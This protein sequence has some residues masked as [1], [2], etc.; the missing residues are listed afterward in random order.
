MPTWGFSDYRF[1]YSEKCKC[2]W[3]IKRNDA[4]LLET[5]RLACP[6]C[7]AEIGKW[8]EKRARETLS[9][10]KS[11]ELETKEVRG[12]TEELNQVPGYGEHEDSREVTIGN[13]VYNLDQFRIQ[14][15]QVHTLLQLTM[16]VA[17]GRGRIVG[18]SNEPI[19]DGHRRVI[20]IEIDK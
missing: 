7:K 2:G 20:S 1:F 4:V 3:V 6:L 14:S 18:E 13:Y 12:V 9:F 5:Y 10:L 15:E 11:L 17:S 8:D 16:H 19:E